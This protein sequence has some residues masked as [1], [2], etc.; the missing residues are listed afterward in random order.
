MKFDSTVDNVHDLKR[1]WVELSENM[2]RSS[3]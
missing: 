1:F 2:C 3:L